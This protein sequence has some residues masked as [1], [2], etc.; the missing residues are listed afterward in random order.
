MN[1]WP[2]LARVALRRDADATDPEIW[3]GRGIY[4]ELHNDMAE[5]ILVSRVDVAEGSIFSLSSVFSACVC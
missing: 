5:Q 1:F 3:T 4:A 2:A